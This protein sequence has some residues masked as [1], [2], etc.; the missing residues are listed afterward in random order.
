MNNPSTSAELL[1]HA[2]EEV[3]EA[4]I[5]DRHPEWILKYPNYI[6]NYEES[7]PEGKKNWLLA[8][9][10]RPFR[11]ALSFPKEN[12]D[13]TWATRPLRNYADILYKMRWGEDYNGIE[14]LNFSTLPDYGI[15][16]ETLRSMVELIESKPLSFN[17]LEN[18]LWAEMGDA[19]QHDPAKQTPE[20]KSLQ[21]I[22]TEIWISNQVVQQKSP[23]LLLP[24]ATTDMGTANR[25]ADLG[26]A[27]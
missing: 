22:L 5:N 11:A 14:G 13:I 3:Y 23:L 27:K 19:Y 21:S 6:N 9:A 1:H 15:P 17:A 25:E 4:M 20:Q 10:E 24:S 7:S 8:E 26:Q 18:M 2:Y 16:P 12:G